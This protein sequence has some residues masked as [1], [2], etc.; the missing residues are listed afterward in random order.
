VGAAAQEPQQ[1]GYELLHPVRKAPWGQTSARLQSLEGAIIGIS[2]A[3][4]LHDQD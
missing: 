3:P 1:A 4:S 2:S